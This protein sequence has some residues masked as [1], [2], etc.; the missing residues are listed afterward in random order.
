[1]NADPNREPLLN[2]TGPSPSFFSM[3]AVKAKHSAWRSQGSKYGDDGG[4][5][6]ERYLEIAR[7]I[8]YVVDEEGHG[9]DDGEG[10]EAKGR[11]KGKGKGAGI[12]GKSVSA[13]SVP[14]G[15]E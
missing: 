5:A 15:E 2:R 8:G 6:K 14:E 9:D 1:M 11:G 12:G 13:M 3:P 10:S 7:S 4:A